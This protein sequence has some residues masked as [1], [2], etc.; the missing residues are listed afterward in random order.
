MAARAR[1]PVWLLTGF[2]GGGETSLRAR[3]LR[4]PGFAGAEPPRGVLTI[5]ARTA[6]A[7]AGD[8]G[9]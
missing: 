5:I 7:M 8:V 6:L 3:R 4:A 2:P 9:A 1:V